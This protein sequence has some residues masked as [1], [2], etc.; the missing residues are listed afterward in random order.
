MRRD[1]AMNKMPETQMKVRMTMKKM[2][3]IKNSSASDRL[4]RQNTVDLFYPARIV[5]IDEVPVEFQIKLNCPSNK[6]V[7]YFFGENTYSVVS[8]ENLGSNQVD[9]ARAFQTKEM[10][11]NYHLA[12]AA[13][14]EFNN[15]DDSD[16]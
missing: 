10:T 13:N 7:V 11:Q 15:T 6:C 14:I 3:T 9:E 12:M 8:N 2:I 1:F 16:E 5:D 4:Y